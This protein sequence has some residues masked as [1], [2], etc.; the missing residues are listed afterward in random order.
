[1]PHIAVKQEDPKQLVFS[2]VQNLSLLQWTWHIR[3]F[4]FVVVVVVVVV[5]ANVPGGFTNGVLEQ[6]SRERR[7]IYNSRNAKSHELA[8]S[9]ASVSVICTQLSLLL[10]LRY[11]QYRPCAHKLR[12]N[13]LLM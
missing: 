9:T 2:P 6:Y 5:V 11:V 4:T 3:I 1:M 13:S 12:L 10:V 7:F 8:E